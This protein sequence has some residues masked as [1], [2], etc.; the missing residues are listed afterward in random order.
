M[1]QYLYRAQRMTDGKFVT[2]ALLH[3]PNSSFVYIATVEAMGCM[4]VNELEGGKTSN[5]ELTRV[6]LKSIEPVTMMEPTQLQNHLEKFLNYIESIED[7]KFDGEPL[8]YDREAI[9]KFLNSVNSKLKSRTKINVYAGEYITE[10]ET[11]K[12]LRVIH[13]FDILT[14]IPISHAFD[15]L[16][17]YE[18]SGTTRGFLITEEGKTWR[19]KGEKGI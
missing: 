6:M 11:G 13:D 19:R 2:G 5:L 7:L 4:V 15:F 18:E 9:T 3:I 12:S 14:S 8:L 17:V 1:K 10:I 16:A